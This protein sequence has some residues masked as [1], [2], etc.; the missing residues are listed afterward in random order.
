M[1]NFR[2]RNHSLLPQRNFVRARNGIFGYNW[3]FSSVRTVAHINK[4]FAV[5]L[6]RLH[7]ALLCVNITRAPPLAFRAA[8]A[9][10]LK[11]LRAETQLGPAEARSAV[12]WWWLSSS[13][14]NYI[15]RHR[16]EKGNLSK[17]GSLPK[18]GIMDGGGCHG[19]RGGRKRNSGLE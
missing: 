13:L 6:R 19:F 2:L 12:L 5:S 10:K 15:I 14:R 16:C 18:R 17:C 1:I 3:C 9:Q 4:I 7:L 11:I 8:L